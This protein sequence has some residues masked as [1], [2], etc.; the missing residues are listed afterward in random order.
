LKILFISSRVPFPLDKGDKLRAYHFIKQLNKNHEVLLFCLSE[1]KISELQTLELKKIA[2][3]VYIF[4]LS[5]ANILFNLFKALFSG[6]PFQVGYFFSGNA[7][8]EIEILNSIHQPQAVFCQLIRTAEYAQNINPQLKLI[9]IMDALS[10]GIERRIP[11][12]KF[13]FRQVLK[14][15]L[16][17]L[18][19]YENNISSKFDKSFIISQ[20]DLGYLPKSLQNNCSVIANGVD[21]DFFYPSKN[22]SKKY[23]II[24]AGNMAYPP[25]VFAVNFL[26][27]EILPLLKTSFPNI[28]LLIAGAN[29]TLDVLNLKSENTQVSGWIE[30]IREAYDS[31]KI[32]VAPMLTGSG[33][34]N[35]ILESMAMQLPCITSPLAAKALTNISKNVPFICENP[36]EYVSV[37]S[38]LL[39]DDEQRV[40]IGEQ[41]REYVIKYYNWS[42]IAKQLEFNLND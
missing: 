40:R 1:E 16:W 35:K 2:S 32:F 41:G 7:K 34:Q 33:L 11:N 5:K 13:L 23:D 42:N 28:K 19:K 9:D 27:K 31:S 25:N 24:F 38:N 12:E 10:K 3:K 37:I 30:D 21:Y 36:N 6:K 22:N 29:P 26:V 8:R 17:R 20:Q 15:E 39:L 18:K 4:H 14:L